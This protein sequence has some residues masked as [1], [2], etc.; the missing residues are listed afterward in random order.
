MGAA[1][2]DHVCSLF[3]LGTREDF[4]LPYIFSVMSSRLKLIRNKYLN[5]II[6][7]RKYAEPLGL[8][9]IVISM[10]KIKSRGLFMSS[11]RRPP[12]CPGDGRW[13]VLRVCTPR[14]DA[15]TLQRVFRRN[16]VSQNIG[17]GLFS[18]RS[19]ERSPLQQPT[20]SPGIFIKGRNF[21]CSFSCLIHSFYY[22]TVTTSFQP[23]SLTENKPSGIH[24]LH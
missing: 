12:S 7:C 1:F 9:L 23:H 20:V 5:V 4:S 16:V 11:R 8:G 10:N 3:R 19:R 17:G 6:A 24:V 14:L 2:P 13:G 22:F 15:L 18:C 21:S